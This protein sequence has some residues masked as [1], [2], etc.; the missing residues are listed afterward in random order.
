LST[1]KSLEWP[2]PE[3]GE[4]ALF[5]DL[6]L[7]T[8]ALQLALSQGTITVIS[9]QSGLKQRLQ[10]MRLV[11]RQS[12]RTVERL[13]RELRVFGWI[14]PVTSQKESLAATPHV[15]TDSGKD[16]LSLSLRS[17]HDFRRL[18][19]S[20]MQQ[21][22]VIPGWFIAR[23]WQIN[24]T[25]QG[26]VILP[27]PPSDWQPKP[28]SAESQTWD[29]A[30]R[31]QSLRAAHLARQS[32]ASAFPVQ[33][34]DWLLAVERSWERLSAPQNHEPEDHVLSSYSPRRR[35]TSAMREAAIGL[36]FNRIPY[37]A[38][39][40]DF[41]GNRPP[42]Y[43]RTFMGWCPRLES[44]ELLFYTDWHPWVNGRLL[45]PV[46]VFRSSAPPE[47]FEPLQAVQHPDN[48]VL[49][50]HQP[51]WATVRRSFLQTLISVHHRITMN[52][53][54]IYVSLLDVRDEVCRQLRLSPLTFDVLLGYAV[55]ELPSD[56]FPWSVALETDIREELTTGSGQY[57][58]PVYLDGVP[59][60][61]IG[62]ARLGTR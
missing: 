10:K 5:T 53:E 13:M 16:A 21:T 33:D 25:G 50:L 42:V 30:L 4:V 40:P 48:R 27:A 52:T 35:L 7:H 20:K 24:P 38:K 6:T 1:D 54:T 32:N 3:I 29:D 47:E 51:K 59:H 37:G 62:L 9:L 8:E 44:L 22:Y 41:P 18:L 36:L 26:E 55:R 56:D 11:V 19:T 34:S 49:W 60:S 43:L 45:F 15:I 39:N 28:R 57:R 31:A 58:R 23:L 46:S 17:P 61:L 12:K 14:E 2:K